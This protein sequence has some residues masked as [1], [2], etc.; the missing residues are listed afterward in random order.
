MLEIKK[1]SV[2]IS[3]INHIVIIGVRLDVRSENEDSN[4]SH[5]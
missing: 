3:V 2:N 5:D 1:C 4:N